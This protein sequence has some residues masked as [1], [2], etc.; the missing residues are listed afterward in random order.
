[1]PFEKGQS[2]NI[3]GRPRNSKNK[4]NPQDEISKAMAS[5]MS[6]QDMVVWL[7]EKITL[8]PEGKQEPLSDSQKTKYLTMLIDLKKFLAK[9]DLV[10]EGKTLPNT[11]SKVKGEVKQFP[12]AIFK[13]SNTQ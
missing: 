11:S 8:E 6:L 3:N 5:G 4:V 12:K 1:M 10:R 9:E 2:G 7:S 13:S